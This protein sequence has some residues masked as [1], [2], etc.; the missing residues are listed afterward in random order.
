MDWTVGSNLPP[1]RVVRTSGG[2]SGPPEMNR[3][4]KKKMVKIQILGHIFTINL[5]REKNFY[6]TGNNTTLNCFAMKKEDIFMLDQ[7]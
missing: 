5:H 4:M 1:A 7:D 3:A 6:K 2:S